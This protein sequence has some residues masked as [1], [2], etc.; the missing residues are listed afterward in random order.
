MVSSSS[1]FNRLQRQSPDRSGRR[2]DIGRAEDG[3]TPRS[4]ERSEQS[5][6]ASEHARRLRRRSDRIRP[7]VVGLRSFPPIAPVLGQIPRDLH[8]DGSHCPVTGLPDALLPIE[9]PPQVASRREGND[10]ADL[11]RFVNRR[12]A[13]ISMT[14]GHA[15]ASLNPRSS[16]SRRTMTLRSLCVGV[17]ARSPRPG[18][19]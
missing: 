3:S 11:H 13:N 1:R 4:G 9:R 17:P 14:D 18:A 8:G 12:Q 2:C 19:Y 7:C 5:V 15:L 10:R 6:D 16:S